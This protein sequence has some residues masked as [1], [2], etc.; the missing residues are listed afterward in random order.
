M[1]QVLAT[2]DQLLEDKALY[3]LIRN[4]LANRFPMTEQTGRNST[5]VEVILRMLAFK[6]LYGLSYKQ[7]EYQVGDS[8]SYVN[9]VG[10]TSTKFPM[11]RASSVGQVLFSQNP[12]SGSTVV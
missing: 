3:Q 2:I 9:S 12:W 7:I 11:T 10:S 5:P 4:S 8:R 6:R 1:D